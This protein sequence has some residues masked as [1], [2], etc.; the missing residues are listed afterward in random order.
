MLED[1]L[2]GIRASVLLLKTLD[3]SSAEPGLSTVESSWNAPSIQREY[4]CFFHISCS[5]LAA[6]DTEIAPLNMVK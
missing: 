2:Q 1:G 5:S 6:W 4:D 3:F